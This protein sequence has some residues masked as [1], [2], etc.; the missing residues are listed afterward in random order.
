[1][2]VLTLYTAKSLEWFESFFDRNGTPSQKISKRRVWTPNGHQLSRLPLKSAEL[3]PL[4]SAA[5]CQM[6]MP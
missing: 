5:G 3:E 1:M 6:V 2:P 4:C